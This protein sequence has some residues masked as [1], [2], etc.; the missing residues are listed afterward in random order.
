M[1]RQPPSPPASSLGFVPEPMTIPFEKI[2]PTRKLAPELE[3]TRKFKQ[4]KATINAIGLI[5]PL[6]LAMPAAG[7][8][9]YVLLDGHLRLMALKALGFIDAPCL[10]AIDDE[11]F[12]YNNRIN[13][14]TSIQEHVMIRRAVERGVSLEKL[15]EAMDLDA[16]QVLKKYKL[17]DGICPE[18]AHLLKDQQFSAEISRVLRK[19][20]PTRQV[21]C[22]ELMIA[23]NSFTVAYA[24]ALLGMTP[25]N[26]LLVNKPRKLKGL[27]PSQMELM[28]REMGNVHAKY[29]LLE[30]DYGQDR[31]LLVLAGGYLK[32]LLNNSAIAK[33]LQKKQATVLTEFEA[34]VRALPSDNGAGA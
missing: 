9:L 23:A 18:A 12:T 30:Q 25:P 11:S 3:T 1:K 29:K 26:A 20:K 32:R 27:S 6:T 21:E 13:R 15:A 10:L 4:I 31:F 16:S 7:S 24:Q 28:E 8:E 34:I 22:A 17:L 19:M 5:E 2:L 33:F 14:V